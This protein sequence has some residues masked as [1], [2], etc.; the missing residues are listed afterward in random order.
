MFS[1]WARWPATSSEKFLGA[2]RKSDLGRYESL[3]VVR[4]A[5]VGRY[6]SLLV[7]RLAASRN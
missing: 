5:D 1:L 2:S 4:L 3:L 6:G 7:V